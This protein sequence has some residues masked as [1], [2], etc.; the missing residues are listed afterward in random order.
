MANAKRPSVNLTE[1]RNVN[2][3]VN[4]PTEVTAE[5][6]KE[7]A[8]ILN[9]HADLHDAANLNPE[10]FY[11]FHSS[12]ATLAA[13]YPN[14]VENG[15][16]VI[17]PTNGNTQFVATFENGQWIASE[18]EAPVQ[19]FNSI[20]DRP[21]EGQED[22][23]YIV[24]DEKIIYLWYNNKWNAFGKDG[25]NGISAYQ[26]AVARGFVGSEDEWLESLRGKSAYQI[27]QANGF[28]GT[29]EE[30][31][32]SLV[33]PPGEAA[34][35]TNIEANEYGTHPTFSNQNDLNIWLLQN[36]GNSSEPQ[37]TA[38]TMNISNITS[39]SFD[40]EVTE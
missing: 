20:A 36:I 4:R 18:N 32:Q 37:P 26:V 5:D 2:P 3:S 28:Q 12:L 8:E 29:E 22:I 25:N 11:R 34:E 23:F 7:I 33:G 6:F 35:F 14:A 27:A 19:F 16:A 39:E 21:D 13:A 38:P 1:K 15:W 31:L 30:W 24:K 10:K 9:D 40:Y 17:I